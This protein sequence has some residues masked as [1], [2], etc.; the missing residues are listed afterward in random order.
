MEGVQDQKRGL[1]QNGPRDL[2]SVKCH[3]PDERSGGEVQG[4]GP[5]VWSRRVFQ[6]RKTERDTIK[7]VIRKIVIY[8]FIDCQLCWK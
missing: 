2:Q 3:G 5:H 6:C 8:F 4:E 1:Q 7:S